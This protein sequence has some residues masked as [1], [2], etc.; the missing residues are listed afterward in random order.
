MPLVAAC[1]ATSSSTLLLQI[2]F[3]LLHTGAEAWPLAPAKTSYLTEGFHYPKVVVT[4]LVAGKPVSHLVSGLVAQQSRQGLTGWSSGLGLCSAIPHNVSHHS[5]IVVF[6]CRVINQSVIL[7]MMATLLVT[8][9]PIISRIA[10]IF[11]IITLFLS[12]LHYL[13]LEFLYL[14]HLLWLHQG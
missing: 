14:P 1:T 5:T 9:I 12:Q 4:D 8:T 3:L 6:I 7:G 13:F 10:T 2:L 11:T